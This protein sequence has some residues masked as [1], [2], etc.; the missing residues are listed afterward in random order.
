MKKFFKFGCGG[1]FALIV[2]I[3]VI[4]T[5]A[6]NDNKKLTDDKAV[7]ATKSIEG[8][9]EEPAAE[10]IKKTSI[11]ED[12]AVGKVTFKVNSVGEVKEISAA[13]GHLKYKPD[14]EG[15]VFL[16]VNATIRN[17]GTEMIQTDSSF[18]KL[19][20][21]SGATYSPSTII[22]ADDKF[23]AFEGINPG[24]ALTGNVVFE[25]PAG[26]TGLDLQVQTG[27]WGTETGTINLN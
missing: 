25:V 17:D 26:L 18:F 5:F 10:E 16:I 11:G 21:A 12:L 4:G 7:V 23:F 13:K 6:S 3:M 1:L 24:L 8:K 22:V 19:K 14:A 27:F 15:A 9:K 2:L 20:A